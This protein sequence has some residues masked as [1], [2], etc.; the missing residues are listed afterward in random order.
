MGYNNVIQSLVL[1]YG[2][3]GRREAL[4]RDPDPLRRRR[5][6]DRQHHHRDPSAAH[7]N[8]NARASANPNLLQPG[9]VM[10]LPR[11]L[12]PVATRAFQKLH[13]SGSESFYYE[14]PTSARLRELPLFAGVYSLP[15]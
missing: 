6:R 15:A 2:D 13:G 5:Q 12:L 1:T 7:P 8:A 9:M 11:P 4:H 14:A 3:S 10:P